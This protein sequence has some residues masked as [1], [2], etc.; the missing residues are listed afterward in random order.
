MVGLPVS[1]SVQVIVAIANTMAAI[2][3]ISTTDSANTMAVVIA[4]NT[5]AA[6]A[7]T[8]GELTGSVVKT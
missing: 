8:V 3:T 6:I 7:T 4:I 2:A 1:C 5:M